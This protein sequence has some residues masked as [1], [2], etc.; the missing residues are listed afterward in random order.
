MLERG[1]EQSRKGAVDV[2]RRVGE[3]L[4]ELALDGLDL[5]VA[6]N[7]TE[8]LET[9]VG[10]RLDL[11]VR[12][13]DDAS[14][15]GDD[16]R[17]RERE[18][19]GGT[20]G[21]GT[22]QLDRALLGTPLLLLKTAE[23]G[24]EDELDTV[25]GDLGHDDLGGVLRGL[26]DVVVSVT[27]E[28]EHEGDDRDNVRLE[29]LA[30]SGGES[31]ESETRAFTS[32]ERALVLGSLG[33]LVHEVVLLERT[34]ST[35]LD[36]TGETVSSTTAGSVRLAGRK[37]RK[38]LVNKVLDLLLA[39]A[40]NK[41]GE[42][43]GDSR[44]DELGRSVERLDKTVDNLGDARVRGVEV[45]R[46]TTEENDGSLLDVVGSLRRRGL[47]EVVLEHGHETRNVLLAVDLNEGN[48][49][50]EHGA[51]DLLV[52]VSERLALDEELDK[53]LDER[54]GDERRELLESGS[55]S[56]ARLPRVRTVDGLRDDHTEAV[57][58]GLKELGLVNVKLLE[59]GNGRLHLVG[60]LLRTV[61]EGGGSTDTNSGRRVG[62][63]TDKG[64][65][66][67][68]RDVETVVLPDV[69]GKSG[70]GLVCIVGGDEELLRV[71]ELSQVDG[72]EGLE[73]RVTD[74]GLGREGAANKGVDLVGGGN[75]TDRGTEVGERGGTVLG[76][77][78]VGANDLDEVADGLETGVV[79]VLELSDTSANDADNQ[80]KLL[81]GLLALDRLG[82]NA[83][84]RNN[85][86][87]EQADKSVRRGVK[88]GSVRH[89]VD[90]VEHASG[91]V[92]NLF[93][94]V[95]LGDEGSVVAKEEGS[96]DEAAVVTK[97]LVG[98]AAEL[99]EDL[100]GAVVN[101]EGTGAEDALDEE[102]GEG[103][104]LV[105]DGA[106]VRVGK[107]GNEL[108]TATKTGL[109]VQDL[110]TDLALL[111]HLG[112]DKS[113]V[114]LGQVLADSGSLL[115]GELGADLLLPL[116][117]GVVLAVLVLDLL[118]GL[119]DVNI[120]L[121][122]RRGPDAA[123]L[124][125]NKVEGR[126][127]EVLL[128][129]G[130]NV[131]DELDGVDEGKSGNGAVGGLGETRVLGRSGCRLPDV[132]EDGLTLDGDH[133]GRV[134]A[135]M[136][137]NGDP[138]HLRLLVHLRV[139]GNND[140][141]GS[142]VLE[143]HLVGLLA[144]VERG[145]E[146]TA[147]LTR[148]RGSGVIILTRLALG[149][150][151]GAL[152]VLLAKPRLERLTHDL[153]NKLGVGGS[154]FRDRR[155]RVATDGGILG[156][157]GEVNEAKAKSNA[158]RGVVKLLVAVNKNTE[159]AEEP[160]LVLGVSEL[161]VGHVVEDERGLGGDG[162][163]ALEVGAV[164]ELGGA[165]NVLERTE[166]ESD[167]NVA[168]EESRGVGRGVGSRSLEVVVESGS[169][170]SEELL[171]LSR[172]LVLCGVDGPGSV[173]DR[174]RESTTGGKLG[175]SQLLA[176]GSGRRSG[177]RNVRGEGSSE[178]RS[179]SRRK[180]VQCSL[181]RLLGNKG[182]KSVDD[183]LRG[184]L[185]ERRHDRVQRNTLLGT[186]T[187]AGLGEGK[188]LSSKLGE[189]LGLGG[190]ADN[191]LREGNRLGAGLGVRRLGGRDDLGNQLGGND[192]R[193][194]DRARVEEVRGN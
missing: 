104:D 23:E 74:V 119:E 77:T 5:G 144:T 157:E 54:V 102:V 176:K 164:D 147:N 162:E 189:G 94:A 69:L 47:S 178:V 2:G 139:V 18:L 120:Q 141:V 65:E 134:K 100:K 34:Q 33:E 108:E 36:D 73:N 152:L 126:G 71:V 171:T 107:R 35:A 98:K 66:V 39:H 190:A 105:L 150:G 188:K 95:V 80:S 7:L 192:G 8:A 194:V 125:A 118:L 87:H 103:A 50:V 172:E 78:G 29:H 145:H 168:L 43:V 60:V 58:L 56:D 86:A 53:R 137:D 15:L 185:G 186:G 63:V 20:E 11:G 61:N 148:T 116:L 165:S 40:G 37:G 124:Q 32:L 13:V 70:V 180:R 31:L 1:L 183:D 12:V 113:L 160:E 167:S 30:E 55:N 92:G 163:D 9:L 88:R 138:R 6:E 191:S 21:H 38:E 89:E 4:H 16:G 52:A 91:E 130:E 81:L 153:G 121:V 59:A 128:G 179:K 122:S 170:R 28:G 156:L 25:A 111:G 93:A 142:N 182:R 44:L 96:S 42:T 135:E 62:E 132:G 169:E 149:T 112:S 22:E 166:G 155:V 146:E 129:L 51:A 76:E 173:T 159:G 114:L 154:E 75:V 68:L 187:L 72:L 184:I 101:Q 151:S 123:F 158:D 99:D 174:A 26:T 175:G 106:D 177:N 85:A 136:L 3:R 181:V 161:G 14:K 84:E 127:V 143:G 83:A 97:T 79:V 90:L 131:T 46:K 64:V 82:A 19:A 45:S 17:E 41:G 48:S 193:D 140:E 10:G 24:R 27:E 67:S 115:F 117:V 133:V 109:N 110:V 49:G 57:K